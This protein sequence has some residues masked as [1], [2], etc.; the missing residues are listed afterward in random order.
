[1]HAIYEGKSQQQIIIQDSKSTLYVSIINIIFTFHIIFDGVCCLMVRFENLNAKIPGSNV[2]R[3]N[4]TNIKQKYFQHT[5]LWVFLGSASNSVVRY[6]LPNTRVLK[7]YFERVR[8][9][10]ELDK[11][12]I[13]K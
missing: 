9:V 5:Q 12:L 1:M 4:V 11:E 13:K 10:W 6:M 3:V 2:D 7:G 8:C